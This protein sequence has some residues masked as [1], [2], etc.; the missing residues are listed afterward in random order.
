MTR[1]KRNRLRH[2]EI[3]SV[4]LVGTPAVPSA[5]FV[6]VKGEGEEELSAHDHAVLDDII[7]KFTTPPSAHTPSDPA[8]APHELARVAAYMGGGR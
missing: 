5:R 6:M 1:K 7:K 2:I 4:S 3:N 8:P